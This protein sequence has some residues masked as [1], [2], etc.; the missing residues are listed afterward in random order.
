MSLSPSAVRRPLRVAVLYGGPSAEREVSLESGREVAAALARRGHRVTPI[1]PGPGPLDEEGFL[2]I[3]DWRRFD[4]AF[5]ALHGT[6][7]EDGTAQ[8]LLDRVGLPYTGSDAEA[9]RLA[10]SKSAAKERF[11]AEGV[12]TPGYVLVHECD[13]RSRVARHAATLGFPLVVKPDAQGSSLGV[14]VVRWPDE[15]PAALERCFALGPFGLLERYVAGQEWTVGFLGARPLP[16]MCVSTP[17]E[18]LDFDAKYRDEATTVSFEAAAP[19]AVVNAVVA[20]AARA[21]RSLGVTGVSR[22]DLRLDPRDVPWV[23]E[24][25]TL[26]GFTPHSAVPTAAARA[27]IGF[28]DLCERALALAFAERSARRAA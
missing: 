20:L 25:N 18:F 19:P 10:F 24:V 7:G 28:E 9:S 3:A 1:D 22:V 27:G 2:R 17:R 21:C 11:A 15:L 16:P 13:P 23:L 4:V 12:A 6:F 8:R 14:S 26:P 5:L